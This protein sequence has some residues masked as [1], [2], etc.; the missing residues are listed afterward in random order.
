L[1][2][3]L[4]AL[5]RQRDYPAFASL[6]P[7]D[8]KEM[9]A[10]KEAKAAVAMRKLELE[11]STGALGVLAAGHFAPVIR[12]RPA[13]NLVRGQMRQIAACAAAN[14]PRKTSKLSKLAHT[15]GDKLAAEI[16]VDC[17]DM[18][19]RAGE[20]IKLVSNA[21][22]EF[23]P[24]HGLPLQLRRTISRV[25]VT[26]GDVFLSHLIGVPT[27]HLS[28]SDLKAI[29]II[30]SFEDGDPIKNALS[31]ASQKFSD[32]ARGKLDLKIVDVRSATEFVE[33]LNS[34]FG[35]IVI[36]DGHGTHDVQQKTGS[37][38]LGR[39]SVNPLELAGKIRRMPPIVVLSAC[40]T[41]PL[42]WSDGSTAIGFLMLGAISVLAT[43]TPISALDAAIFSGRLMLRLADFVPMIAGS[44]QRWS[45]V[46]TGL[47]RMAYVTDILRSFEGRGWLSE[48]EYLEIHYQSNI[49]INSRN[50][51]W[52]EEVLSSISKKTGISLPNVQNYWRDHAYF[53]S[54]LQYVHLGS[55]ERIIIVADHAKNERPNVETA[56]M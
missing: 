28:A 47:L 30:R 2:P 12:I 5:L 19:E 25:P 55:P 52:F 13:V 24:I 38:Q 27:I 20:G 29:L 56:T 44:G 3:V 49:S 53:T 50:P 10:P 1:V 48:D 8:L 4:R 9:L 51:G 7:D 26:P 46:I 23:L 14:G 45:D 54:T 37:I 39:H 42:E 21:P 41:H 16:G 36:F 33:A 17:L 11:L 18:I 35:R 43:V 32:S 15:L 34:F 31:V 22:L 6:P 40:S